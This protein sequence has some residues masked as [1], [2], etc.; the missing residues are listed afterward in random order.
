MEALLAAYE[1]H[2]EHIAKR[3]RVRREAV[4]L[5]SVVNDG[6]G[7]EAITVEESLGK[8]QPGDELQGDVN[9]RTLRSLLKLVDE[10]GFERVRSAILSPLPT[11][12]PSQRNCRT[13][14]FFG[15]FDARFAEPP[16]TQ[17]PRRL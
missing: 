17:V 9:F 11:L 16:S 13:P 2:C 12:R 1:P 7:R 8:W 14:F 6:A 15:H 10:K 3:A 5:R 4:A